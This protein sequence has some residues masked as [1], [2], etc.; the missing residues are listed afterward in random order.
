MGVAMITITTISQGTDLEKGRP[1]TLNPGPLH[2]PQQKQ[3]IDPL[4]LL[5]R[6][7]D[8]FPRLADCAFVCLFGKRQR[9]RVS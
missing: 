9:K 4:L 2:H 6:S 5:D 8:A 7:I 3:A 1:T